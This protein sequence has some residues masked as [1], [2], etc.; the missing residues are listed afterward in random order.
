MAKFIRHR[1][2]K[3]FHVNFYQKWWNWK[4]HTM[5]GFAF[6]CD[7]KGVIDRSKLHPESIRNLDIEIPRMVAEGKLVE[8]PIQHIE[9]DDVE[10]ICAIIKCNRCGR[11][12]ELQGFTN[13]CE[14]GADYDTSGMELA[15]RE[16]WCEETGES[17]ADILSV[18]S[19][20]PEELLDGD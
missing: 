2:C 1:D 3:P 13:T 8:G 11:H 6:D 7:S 18:D 12:V 16:Q 17:I 10:R 4:G 14:C 5:A 20:D 19:K 15:P 9:Y